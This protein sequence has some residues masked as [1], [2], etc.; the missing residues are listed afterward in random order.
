MRWRENSKGGALRAAIRPTAAGRSYAIRP[1]RC[2]MISCAEPG[3][4]STAGHARGDF[5]NQSRLAADTG[6]RLRSALSG[7]VLPR[8][9]TLEVIPNECVRDKREEKKE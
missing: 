3:G 1:S 4:S 5:A 8:T 2:R 9:H 7:E 6:A